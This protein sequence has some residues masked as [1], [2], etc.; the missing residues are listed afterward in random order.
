MQSHLSHGLPQESRTRKSWARGRNIQVLCFFSV[1]QA[2]TTPLPS[3]Y[4]KS[5]DTVGQELSAIYLLHIELS[6]TCQLHRVHD[7]RVLVY[8]RC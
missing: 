1:S 4:D 8:L 6:W 7:C 5:I 2:P 3:S